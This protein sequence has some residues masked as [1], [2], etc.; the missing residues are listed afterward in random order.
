MI[1]TR[2]TATVAALVIAAVAAAPAFAGG[3]RKSEEPFVRTL[4]AQPFVSGE[5]KNEPPF[6]SPVQDPPTVVVT[7]TD[8]GFSWVDALIGAAAGVG[9]TCLLGGLAAFALATRRRAAPA[10]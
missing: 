2:I 7:S 4:A 5:P 6:I 8:D 1:S 9:A 10:Q 3:E